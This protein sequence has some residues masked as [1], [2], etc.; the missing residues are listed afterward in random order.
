M[1]L[2][3][4]FGGMVVRCMPKY[5]LGGP[6]WIPFMTIFGIYV[7]IKVPNIE[8]F[9]ACEVYKSR[10]VSDLF[11]HQISIRMPPESCLETDF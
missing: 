6:H 11:S 8:K 4:T 9:E 7:S 10:E 1:G 5:S 2:K 3:K